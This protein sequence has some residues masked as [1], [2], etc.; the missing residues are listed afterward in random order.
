M[1]NHLKVNKK[2]GIAIFLMLAIIYHSY[3]QISVYKFK[4]PD[5]KINLVVSNKNKN[6]EFSLFLINKKEII[7]DK[8]PMGL[9]L[10]GVDLSKNITITSIKENTVKET[11]NTVVGKTKKV[12]NHYNEYILE[13]T[14][15]GKNKI[16]FN[17]VFRCYN[18]GVAFR[19]IIPEQDHLDSIKIERD[20]TVL[21]FS[22]DFTFWATNKEK[23]NLGP[24]LRS[25]ASLEKIQSPV[26]IKTKLDTYIG[27]HEAAIFN[28]A[29]FTLSATSEYF[30]FEFD[31]EKYITNT[32]LETSWRTIFIGNTPGDLIESNLLVNLNPSCKIEDT[33]W[34]KPGKSVW[35]WRVA[36]YIAKDG[37]EYGL[38]TTS[39]KRFIDFAS[40]NNIQYLLMDADWYGDEFSD[41][42]NPSSSVNNIN[43]VENMNYA[44]EKG[45]GIILY[46]NDIGA[47]KFGL[48]K[49]LKQFS[50]WGAVGVKYGFMTGEGQEKVKYTRKVVELCAKYKL[51][52]DFHDYPI[53]PSGD[54]RT[55]PNLITREFG[56]AQADA[57]SSYFPET[58]VSSPFINMIAGPLDLTSGW[59]DLNNAHSRK[60][61]FKEIPGTV[62][63]EVAKLIVI[64]TGWIVLPD[65]PEEYLRKDDLFDC[66]RK[67][68][69]QFDSLLVLDGKIGEYIS[70][71]RRS[72]DDWFIGSLTNRNA[73]EITI[74]FSFLPKDKEYEA[75]IYMDAD[76]THYL[77][78]KESY[79][80]R[81]KHLNSNTKLLIKM[82]PGGGNAIYLKETNNN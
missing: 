59:F 20:L 82:A 79:K 49:V 46:L 64:Y 47:K 72:E 48:E 12:V 38:N 69:V 36:G 66:I 4:S 45:I 53:P 25:K 10:N 9:V 29:P 37:F 35:D 22:D 39:H 62:V 33:S 15:K 28:F 8:S 81:K 61:V 67:M 5:G 16:L 65:A 51:M 30:N 24:I 7:L 63:A 80:I 27:I 3:S 58:I 43:I 73:R 52:V 75:T 76:K 42:S 71:A 68:P 13:C 2:I 1:K 44:K 32:T 31:I 41:N 26:I 18:D 78:N 57:K 19:Y 6:V 14:N 21:N 70:V 77:N 55:W 74:D 11:W 56:W 17:I 60:K 54:I 23:H 34:I 40:K 50:E